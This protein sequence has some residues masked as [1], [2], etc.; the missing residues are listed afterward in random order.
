[1]AAG[2]LLSAAHVVNRDPEGMLVLFALLLLTAVV[3]CWLVTD[4][5]PA[6]ALC[7]AVLL[8][9]VT[10]TLPDLVYVPLA[11]SLQPLL[12]GFVIVLPV[13]LPAAWLLLR[14]QQAASPRPVPKR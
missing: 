5:R 8:A 9:E 4:A 14:R 1:V 10:V 12:V 11:D 3:I 7:L 13:L 2:T 6:F